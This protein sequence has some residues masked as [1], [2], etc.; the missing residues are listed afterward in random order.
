MNEPCP[1]SFT[2]IDI[3]AYS[4]RLQGPY[5]SNSLSISSRL[6]S[7]IYEGIFFISEKLAIFPITLQAVLALPLLVSGF[8]TEFGP[9]TINARTVVYRAVYMYGLNDAPKKK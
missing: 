3:G 7:F 4:I 5:Q 2:R 8:Y 9:Y 1:N 6:Y